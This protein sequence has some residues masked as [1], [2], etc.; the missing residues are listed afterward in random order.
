MRIVRISIFSLAL[1]LSVAFRVKG[2]HADSSRPISMAFVDSVMINDSLMK[3]LTAFID[4]AQSPKTLLAIELGAGNGFFTSKNATAA[5]GY[6]TK[7]FL[8]PTITYVHKSG[9]GISASAYATQDLGE[10]VIYQGVITPTFGISKKNWSAGIS[11]SRYINKDSVSFG[12]NPLKND[13]YAYGIYK[14]YWIEP[15]A[16]FDFS[17]D[18]YKLEEHLTITDNPLVTVINTYNIHAHT[19]SAIGTVQHDFNWYGLLTGGDLLAIT[20]TL[21]ALFD[22]SNYDIS[23]IDHLKAGIRERW[24]G[25]FQKTGKATGF[26]MQSVSGLLDAV[27]TFRHYLIEPQVLGNYFVN[28]DPGVS[29]FRISFLVNVG[30]VF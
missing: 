21:M 22:A 11:Y 19:M 15:G 13:L 23:V 17:F 6:S 2:Q 29:P 14:K 27:Y 4:S 10:T 30:L 25:N 26:S 3:D 7:N 20:P 24:A 12:L 1:L 5:T 28:T 18:S 8:S 9:L 16:A